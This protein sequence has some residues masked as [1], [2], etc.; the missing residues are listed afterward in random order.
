MLGITIMLLLLL[1]I[2]FTSGTTFALPSENTELDS[3]SIPGISDINA[4]HGNIPIYEKFEISFQLSGVWSNPFDPD[5]VAVD[6]VFYTPD[7]KTLT[8]P[9][10]YF[11]DYRRTHVNG[12][13]ILIPAGEPVWKVRF[14]PTTPGTYRYVLRMTNNGQTVEVEDR[15]FQCTDNSNKHGFLRVSEENPYYFRFDDGT[16]FFVVGENIGTLGSSG[17]M[18]ADKCYTSLARAGGN[19]ADLY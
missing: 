8:M 1:S 14:S 11:Q 16:S 15:T 19:F 5:Q 7:G 3:A 4:N 12:R 2:L 10:F 9:G 6:C 13:E 17:T 18:L